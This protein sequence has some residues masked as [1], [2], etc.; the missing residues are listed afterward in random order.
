MTVWEE[1]PCV[2]RRN[3]PSTTGSPLVRLIAVAVEDRRSYCSA[4]S[5]VA[6][7]ESVRLCDLGSHGSVR[8]SPLR[9]YPGSHARAW[10][11]Q[12]AGLTVE[13]AAREMH[14][15]ACP[16]TD[17]S[18]SEARLQGHRHFRVAVHD[19]PQFARRGLPTLGAAHRPS[20]FA[21]GQVLSSGRERRDVTSAPRPVV[22]GRVPRT[23]NVYAAAN[24][25]TSATG[26]DAAALD[27]GQAST[28]TTTR[29][30]PTRSQPCE[31]MRLRM[32]GTAVLVLTVLCAGDWSAATTTGP[33]TALGDDR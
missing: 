16:Q 15:P 10:C 18:V 23:C 8:A 26:M 30:T 7:R 12:R 21:L 6:A 1:K 17:E 33:M 28:A 24:A 32:T 31:G 2:R 27:T 22:A 14:C 9:G 29:P 19:Q 5:P 4:I 3:S 11:G 13:A 25:A 20:S